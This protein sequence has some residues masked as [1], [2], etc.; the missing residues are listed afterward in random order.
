MIARPL[1]T[2]S[3]LSLML[4]AMHVKSPFPKV[5]CLDS[6]EYF[7]AKSGPWARGAAWS[8]GMHGLALGHCEMVLL[9]MRVADGYFSYQELARKS[10]RCKSRVS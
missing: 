4:S 6:L 1:T 2:A 8:I 7:Q 5:L 10:S 9:M 3:P